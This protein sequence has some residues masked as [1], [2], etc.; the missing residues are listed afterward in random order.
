MSNSRSL[1]NNH[2]KSSLSVLK[3]KITCMVCNNQY[4]DPK[5]LPCLHSFCQPCLESLQVSELTTKK[6]VCPE[7]GKKIIVEKSVSFPDA[8]CIN[9]QI[10][11]YIF[12]QKIYGIIESKCEKCT[13]K[14]AKAVYFCADCGRFICHLCVS[15]HKSWSE[16]SSHKLLT[17]STL[18]ECYQKYIPKSSSKSK[19]IHHEK[20]CSVYCE[21][22]QKEICH[23]CIIKSHR[24]H[25]YNLT[26]D[27]V[28]QH[29]VSVK[30]QL[31]MIDTVPGELDTAM[32]KLKDISQNFSQEGVEV[33]AKLDMKF[34]ELEKMVSSRHKTLVKELV[35]KVDIKMKTLDNQRKELEHV[36]NIVTS[37]KDFVTD[38]IEG[39]HNSEFFVLKK[40][41]CDRIAEVSKGFSATELT[42]VE[43]PTIKFSFDESIINQLSFSGNI[44]DGSILHTGYSSAM[45]SSP[46][47]WSLQFFVNEVVKFYVSLSSSYFKIRNN[48]A[49][50][51]SAEIHCLR[52]NSICPATIAIN[53][54]GFAKIQC[55]F[56]ER[57]RYFFI[58][59][60]SGHHISGSPFPFFLR[61]KP[62][63][64]FQ[65]PLRSIVK[66]ITPKGL[67]VNKKNQIIVSQEDLHN[68]MIFGKR[69]R[70]VLS[71]G[72]Y[73]SGEAQFNR[74]SGVAVDSINCIYVSDTMNN[75]V[76]KFDSEGNFIKEFTGEGSICGNLNR[77][78]GIKVNRNSEIY[79]VDRGNG[80]I[81]ILTTDLVY[82]N[83]FGSLGKNEGQF[84]D[85]WD[86]A[87]DTNE[88]VYVTDM[89]MHTVQIFDPLGE[90]RGQIGAQGTQKS[91]LNRPSGISIDIFGRI[92]ICEF[93]NHRVSIFHTSSEFIDCF[94]IGLSM[95]NPHS[96]VVDEDG[97]IYVSSAEAIHVF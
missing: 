35:E 61:P 75:R 12:L 26:A 65:A 95:V 29:K 18:K 80:R 36:K 66:L 74:P 6:L 85:P 15:I 42:P 17:L 37:C 87:F 77:P 52:D 31:L 44:S 60:I 63:L 89:K 64:Q 88:L 90:Y 55:C 24:S 34:K 40:Q 69:C 56:A 51:I 43:E 21:T 3:E 4:T 72:S 62:S 16:F 83:S 1:S 59:K 84:E 68:V 47:G 71:F 33:R 19:C 30:E 5:T 50:Q 7:C 57:G 94:S 22:C 2:S 96:I 46:S 93:G 79:I 20:D 97:F 45:N 86:V 10:K 32:E 53:K 14:T 25:H 8:F 9:R 81:I 48:P 23:E 58:V 41:M 28:K 78:T 92:F 76:Q 91:R 11:E 27:S 39:D 38:T 82:L 73:G 67:A 54:S 13:G 70:K 49:E